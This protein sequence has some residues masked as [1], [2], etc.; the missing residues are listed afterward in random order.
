M[1]FPSIPLADRRL[2]QSR[3]GRVRIMVAT[4][5]IDVYKDH[6]GLAAPPLDECK[7]ITCRAR[8]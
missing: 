7:T 6:N 4:K 8:G 2:E 3:R 5:P 1:I